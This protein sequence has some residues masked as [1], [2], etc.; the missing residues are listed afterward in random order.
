M[1]FK[2]D[3][4]DS[5]LSTYEVQ[6]D[7]SLKPVSPSPSDVSVLRSTP[8]S[9]SGTP[10]RPKRASGADSKS[11]RRKTMEKA[12]ELAIE[13]ATVALKQ[14]SAAI[15]TSCGATDKPKEN[16]FDVF[17][18][19]IASKLQEMDPEAAKEIEKQIVGLL[20]SV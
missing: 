17:G 18:R 5:Q 15:A 6:D 20:Y 2:S 8:A 11:K 10:T 14:I 9:S 13:D 16:H 4:E 3:V 12:S 19:F 7:Y 1:L